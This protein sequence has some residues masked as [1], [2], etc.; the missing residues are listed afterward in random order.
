MY[1]STSVASTKDLFDQAAELHKAGK[2]DAALASFAKL[3][4]REPTNSS[5]LHW[6]GYIHN[7][8]GEH[9]R[10][11]EV[12]KRAIVERPGV[13]AF[14]LTLGGIVQESRAVEASNWLLSDG[15]ESSIR[16]IPRFCALSVWRSRLRAVLARRSRT[17]VAPSSCGLISP[18]L[19]VTSRWYYGSSGSLTRRSNTCVSPSSW[20][21]GIRRP[22][23]GSRWFCSTAARPRKL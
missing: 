20:R 14:H 22:G 10:A 7:Q 16:I 12:L 9:D 4:G 19:T 6:I 1:K 8:R 18:R 23:A 5:A 3:A 2:I 17:S 11:V 13:P 15:A 21:P